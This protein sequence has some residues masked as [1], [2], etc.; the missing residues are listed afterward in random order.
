MSNARYYIQIKDKQIPVIIRSFKNSNVFKLYFKNGIL[1]ISKPKFM[2]ESV[3]KKQIKKNEDIIYT[4]YIQI[5]KE[6]EKLENSKEKDNVY[7]KYKTKEMFYILGEDFEI[8]RNLVN[9]SYFNMKLD[10]ENKQIVFNVPN[11]VTSESDIKSVGDKLIKQILK[12]ETINY[13]NKFGSC[14]TSKKALHFTSRLIMLPANVID[15]IIIHELCHIP[16]PNHSKAF[17]DLVI[18][19]KSD[20]KEIDKWLKKNS[21][22]ILF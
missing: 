3:L 9:S 21:N 7:K 2:R 17:Y 10:K 1:N 5:L 6:Q 4:N 12:E 20:Y 16:Q 14:V 22:L 15:A 8:I 11:D 19:Y 18:S 13:L